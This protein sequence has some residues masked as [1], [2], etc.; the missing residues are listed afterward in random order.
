MRIVGPV[1]WLVCEFERSWS[2]FR[3]GDAFRDAEVGGENVGACSSG[4][5]IDVCLED[6][7]WCVV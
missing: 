1:Y 2:G 5:D 6:V 3:I 7:R 4:D